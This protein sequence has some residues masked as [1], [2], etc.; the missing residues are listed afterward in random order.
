MDNIYIQY[1]FITFL[2]GFA[3]WYLYGMIRNNFKKTDEGGCS[4]NCGCSPKPKKNK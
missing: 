1:A 3:V 2:I 4:S